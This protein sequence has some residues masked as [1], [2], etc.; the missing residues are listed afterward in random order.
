[1]LSHRHDELRLHD[2]ELA[3]EEGARLVL[4]TV[5]ELQAVRAVDRH[6]IDVEPLQRL[7]ERVACAAEERDALLQ[8][9]GAR[10]VL[11]EKDVGER[12]ARADHRHP[13]SSACVRDLVTERIDLGDRLLQV[14]LVDVGN[15]VA[16]SGCRQLVDFQG[17]W[18]SAAQR[19]IGP[20]DVVVS[21]WCLR[22]PGST[23][24]RRCLPDA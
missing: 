10:L 1:V 20:S 6:R 2:V 23:G 18:G 17:M 16:G 8:L 7:Q 5:C 9:R 13:R 3:Y 21:L 14:L 24:A 11:Q 22:V 4:V 12:M 15:A 19:A